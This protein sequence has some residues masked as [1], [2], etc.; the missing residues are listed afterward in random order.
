MI[1]DKTHNL[2]DVFPYEKVGIKILPFPSISDSLRR[3]KEK[4]CVEEHFGN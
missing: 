2:L 4:V 1:V 3:S